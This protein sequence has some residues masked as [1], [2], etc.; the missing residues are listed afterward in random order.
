MERKGLTK[1]LT[2]FSLLYTQ[3]LLHTNFMKYLL[4]FPLR[5]ATV[6]LLLMMMKKKEKKEDEMMMKRRMMMMID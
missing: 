3:Y 4:L 2:H 5:I 6:V 1:V